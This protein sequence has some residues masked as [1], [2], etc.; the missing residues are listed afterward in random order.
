MIEIIIDLAKLCNKFSKLGFDGFDYTKVRGYVGGV[1]IGWKKN[2][3]KVC[4]I[5][6]HFQFLHVRVNMEDEVDWLLTTV[7]ASPREEGGKE[8]W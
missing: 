8:L 3:I 2:K 1:T 7:Y 5:E 6:K 4:T